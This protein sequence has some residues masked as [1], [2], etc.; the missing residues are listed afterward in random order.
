MIGLI[1][2]RTMRSRMPCAYVQ[3]QGAG[4]NF[5]QAGKDAGR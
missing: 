1:S 4:T 5:L 2:L 3:A